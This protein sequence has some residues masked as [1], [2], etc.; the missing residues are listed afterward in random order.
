MVS[1]MLHYPLA[2]EYNRFPL[3]LA[4]RDVS[5]G[6]IYA[7]QRQKFHTDDVDQSELLTRFRTDFT[8]S[9]WNFYSLVADVPSGETSLA[10]RGKE[11]RLYSHANDPFDFES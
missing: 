4:A 7:T 11:K 10:A 5:P 8:P 3:L 2:C 9:I 1:L 6:G